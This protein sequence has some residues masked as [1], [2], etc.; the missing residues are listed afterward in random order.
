MEV[1]TAPRLSSGFDDAHHMTELAFDGITYQSIYVNGTIV[2]T[3]ESAI[4]VQLPEH[5]TVQGKVIHRQ[6]GIDSWNIAEVVNLH[7][8][9]CQP[10]K[11]YVVEIYD[12]EDIF[13]VDMSE[14]SIEGVLG[15][16][17]NTSVHLQ[18]A[19]QL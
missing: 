14:V 5:T 13:Q 8:T 9:C 10:R 4:E 7:L 12:A 19:S 17:G 15:T 3:S 2:L 6:Q 1:Y 16:G 18:V 11:L